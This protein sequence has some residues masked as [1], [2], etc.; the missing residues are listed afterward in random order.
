MSPLLSV[1]EE[2]GVGGEI[3]ALSGQNIYA[4]YQ[5]G[6]CTAACP[7]S[8]AP[9]QV[10][11]FLQLGQVEKAMALHTP[12]ECA[13]CMTC[14]TVCPK[15]VN[16]TRIMRALRTLD[17]MG[18]GARTNG[19]LAPHHQPHGKPM[20]SF[21]FANIHRLSRLGSALAPFSNWLLNLPGGNLVAHYLLGIH[22]E[23]SLPAFTRAT[24]PSWF[25]RHTPLGDGH[26]GTVLLFHDTFMDYYV[27]LVGIAAT[28][29]LEKAGFQ[30]E[31]TDTVCCARPM[32]SKGFLSQAA[33]HARTWL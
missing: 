30:V 2:N 26:R 16:P 11:R 32:I 25:S 14:S 12:W 8:F 6:K 29:L 7:F 27:P 21:L 22:K 23:R 10:V 31:L 24:F 3:A 18:S 19:S 15:G 28:E 13:F 1:R 33:T 20:R 5:C 4:C 9:H 17:Q